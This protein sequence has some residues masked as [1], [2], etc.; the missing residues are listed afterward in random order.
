MRRDANHA[1][2]VERATSLLSGATTMRPVT[3]APSAPARPSAA[4]Q[5]PSLAVASLRRYKAAQRARGRA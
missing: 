3:S 4:R 1:G 2:R 5:G